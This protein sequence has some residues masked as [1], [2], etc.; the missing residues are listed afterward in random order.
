MFISSINR[1]E[2]NHL[3]ESNMFI[4]Q[5]CIADMIKENQ[6]ATENLNEKIR[7]KTKNSLMNKCYYFDKGF[8]SSQELCK[9]YHPAKIC[10]QWIND[11]YCTKHNCGDRHPRQCR[12]WKRGNC[13]RKDECV[14]IHKKNMR[15]TNKCDQCK[16]PT[17]MSYY[18]E[19]CGSNF[20]SHCTI[21]EAHFKEFNIINISCN[22]LHKTTNET[23]MKS[24]NNKK[25]PNDKMEIEQS[26]IEVIELLE[27][28]EKEKENDQFETELLNQDAHKNCACNKYQG[29]IYKCDKCK[30]IFCEE[31]PAAPLKVDTEIHCLQCLVDETMI[32]TS[33]PCKQNSENEVRKLFDNPVCSL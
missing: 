15:E 19:F 29:E 14:Y 17:H 16:E 25:D 13:W 31:C 32:Y 4:N 21:K 9:Y 26:N 33:T 1:L 30:N 5:E 12:Y 8:C 24:K 28:D 2:K 7:E 27:Y 23:C 18:C 11:D 3:Y 6:N 20:C 10:D 22:N